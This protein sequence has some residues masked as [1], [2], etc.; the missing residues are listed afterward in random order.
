MGKD[1]SDLR[2]ASRRIVANE[3]EDRPCCVSIVFNGGRR[4]AGLDVLTAGWIDGVRVHYGLAPVELFEHR[5]ENGVPVPV[6]AMTR[7]QA[8]AV[9][10]QSVEYIFDF[11]QA[12]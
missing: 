12:V 11:E 4:H 7:H 1:E 5:L 6:A 8:N 10:L 2:V 3:A 9:S